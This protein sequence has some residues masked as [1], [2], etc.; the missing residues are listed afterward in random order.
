MDYH[1]LYLRKLEVLE[2]THSPPLPVSD[3]TGTSVSSSMKRLVLLYHDESTFH[4]NDDQGWVWSE[5]WG[6]QI[7]PKGQG[8]ELMV[9]DFIDEH[10]G[11]LALSD[12]EYEEARSSHPNLWKEARF[13][14]KYGCDSRLLEQ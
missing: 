13:I 9:S 14:L 2:S 1:K 6:Q 4:S 7:R 11:Y 8:R 12:A 5:K 10:N 3:E